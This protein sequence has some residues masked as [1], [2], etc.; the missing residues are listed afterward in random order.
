MAIDG[1]GMKPLATS[2]MQLHARPTAE[3]Q[4]GRLREASKLYERQFLGEMMKAMRSTVQESGLIKSSQA[5]KIFREQLDGQY[6]DK[7]ADEGGLGLQQVIYNQLVDKYGAAL[8]IKI[9]AAR[10][11]GPLALGSKDQFQG[12]IVGNTEQKTQMAFERKDTFASSNAEALTELKSP[13]SGKVLSMSQIG[14]EQYE[15]KIQHTPDLVGQFVFRGMPNQLTKGQD[16]K[17]GMGLGL[18]SPESKQFFWNIEV[19]QSASE[20]PKNAEIGPKSE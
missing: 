7:W 3:Q 8:G 16:I 18:L 19:N 14:G 6:L 20:L 17:A 13:W 9:P 11:Q 12:R 2:P 1:S 10:P 5:E 4:E 15:I